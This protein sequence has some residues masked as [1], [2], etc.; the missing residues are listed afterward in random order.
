MTYLHSFPWKSKKLRT[1]PPRLQSG[2]SQHL[3][4]LRPLFF[5]TRKNYQPVNL[6]LD[7]RTVISGSSSLKNSHEHDFLSRLYDGKNGVRR[8]YLDILLT[9]ILNIPSFFSKNTTLSVVSYFDRFRPELVDEKTGNKDSQR[10]YLI[11]I[12]SLYRPFIPTHYIVLTS[13]DKFHRTNVP[14]LRP[15]AG[16]GTRRRV[17]LRPTRP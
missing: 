7:S 6:R 5:Y 1:H 11:D 17:E 8:F 9:F 13:R 10:Q 16:R 3:F 15:T 14:F 4:P 2:F 12:K